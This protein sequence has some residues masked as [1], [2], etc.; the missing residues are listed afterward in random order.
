MRNLSSSYVEIWF[1]GL[2]FFAFAMVASSLMRA[3]GDIARPGYLMA[4]SALLQIA[5]GPAL[6]FGA[7]EFS[8][9][10]L[11]G[12]AIAFVLARTT[13]FLLYVYFFYRD[14]AL[15]FSTRDIFRSFSDVLYVGTP[16]IAA[17]VIGPATMTF[18]TKL[19]ATYGSAAIAGFS[20]ASRVETMFAMVLWSLSMSLAPF[21]GQN[22]GGGSITRVK[23][24][25]Y[26]ANCFS[27]FWGLFSFLILAFC[28]HFILMTLTD[29]AAVLAYATL[30]MVI[31]PLGMG[32]MGVGANVG[33]GFNALAPLIISICQM[34]FLTVPLSLLGNSLFGLSGIFIGG[35][36]SML[37][38]AT[39]GCF[40][41]YS[42][43]DSKRSSDQIPLRVV[44]A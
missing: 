41:F 31:A 33:S 37:I 42:V 16:A 40:W 36:L 2:P 4:L 28:S 34:L 43:L 7:G 39:V 14:K 20:L 18:V 30:Y 29:D 38:S 17:N 6:I 13:G 44:R 9:F 25:F 19:V 1:F 26:L 11:I 35:I 15:I 27:L 8:G 12:A 21:I 22:W 3:M 24:S 10:G 5:F 23:R 32:V